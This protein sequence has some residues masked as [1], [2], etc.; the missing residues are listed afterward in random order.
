MKKL[1][2]L[3]LALSITAVSFGQQINEFEPNPAGADPANQ[4]FE[5]K[6][7]PSAAFSGWIVSIEGDPGASNPGSVNDATSVSGTFD[8]NG[9]LVVSVPD[10]ENPSFTIVLVDNFTGT[11]GDDLDTND[12]GTID[13]TSKWNTVYDAIGIPDDS[14]VTTLLYGADLGGTDFVY[15]GSEP[16][17]VFRDGTTDDLYAVNFIGDTNVYDVSAT[18]VSP[19]DFDTDPTVATTFGSANPSKSTA[20]VD[21]YNKNSFSIYPNPTSTGSVRIV[22]SSSS[23]F[24]NINVAVYDVLGKQVINK[25]M[26][27][28]KLNVSALNTGIYIMKLSQGKATSTKKLVIK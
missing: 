15:T 6:G 4:S 23:N 22:S 5:L 24:G 11:V 26:T 25:M 16:A 21:D 14:D 7:T 13:D 1:Y 10:L 12:D 28:D 20:S 27:S 3:L 9:L 17:I 8:A 2:F 19:G 18:V